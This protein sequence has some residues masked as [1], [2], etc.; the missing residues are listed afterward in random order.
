MLLRRLGFWFSHVFVLG[1]CLVL[2]GGFVVQAVD[3]D[4]PCPLCILQRMAMMLC[5]LGGAFVVRRS[6]DGGVTSG[7]LAT[8]Y[9]LAIVG[10]V[11]G[12]AISGRQVLLHVVP[13]D[14]GYGDPVLGLHLYTWAFIT[15][16]VATVTAAIN[17]A[18]ADDIAWG[19]LRLRW[20]STAVLWALGAV[21][22]A[23]AVM[24]FVEEGLNW[25]LPDD[26]QRYELLY[27]LGIKG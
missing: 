19:D 16:G 27:D 5:A 4:M 15:F 20:V 9:G 2:A 22:A 13:P 24:V 26:P 12:M 8:G 14:P 18:L 10:A 23:N 21:I 25:T 3:A 7:D 6:L 11:A 17:L 1:F